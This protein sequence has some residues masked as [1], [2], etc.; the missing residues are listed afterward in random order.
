MGLLV[1]IIQ[2]TIIIQIFKPE[3]TG[4]CLVLKQ[5]PII[6]AMAVYFGPVLE[7]TVCYISIKCSGCLPF[8]G[9]REQIQALVVTFLNGG[10]IADLVSFV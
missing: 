3:I 2:N 10:S 5:V 4:L 7:Y 8:V 6:I 9:V 1:F